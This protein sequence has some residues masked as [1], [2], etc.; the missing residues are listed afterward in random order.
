M[1]LQLFLK[2]HGGNSFFTQYLQ[3]HQA[4]WQ[5]PDEME[6]WDCHSHI[7]KR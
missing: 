4:P 5:V 6:K 2:R 3:K 1:C 7:Q